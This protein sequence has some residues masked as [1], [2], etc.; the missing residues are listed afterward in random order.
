M[1]FDMVKIFISQGHPPSM[2][3][4]INLKIMHILANTLVLDLRFPLLTIGAWFTFEMR[5]LMRNV[6]T[7]D[8]HYTP[9]ILRFANSFHILSFTTIF[10]NG[11]QLRVVCLSIITCVTR[12]AL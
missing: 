10:G 2:W 3:I 5:D 7:L 1:I 11:D 6:H 8:T 9:L 12:N 4:C